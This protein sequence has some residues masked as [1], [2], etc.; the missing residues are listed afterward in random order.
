MKPHELVRRLVG[1]AGGAWAVAK[2]MNTP[3]FQGTLHK[4]CA[5]NVPEPSRK[6]ADRI[7]K[8]FKIPVEAIYEPRVA[9]QIFVER[10]GNGAVI[11]PVVQAAAPIQPPEPAAQGAEAVDAAVNTIV[12]NLLSHTEPRRRLIADALCLLVKDP[13]EDEY[14]RS[15]LLLLKSESGKHSEKGKRRARFSP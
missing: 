3:N 1:D 6:S 15:L 12:E 7:A 11:Q 9:A 13:E 14:L 4:I 5:G 8:H 10:F 2:A